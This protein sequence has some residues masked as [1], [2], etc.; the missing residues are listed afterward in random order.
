MPESEPRPHLT[1][2][3]AD[4]NGGG[5]SRAS[6]KVPRVPD[7]FDRIFGT[8]HDRDLVALISSHRVHATSVTEATGLSA[9]LAEPGP[10]VTAVVAT[11]PSV[12]RTRGS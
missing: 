10:G 8:P 11:L 6:S 1:Y 12:A 9:A 2:V 4:N 3:V 5:S 7:T